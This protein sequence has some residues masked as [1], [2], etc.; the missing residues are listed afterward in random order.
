[1]LMQPC[2]GRSPLLLVLRQN[3]P[4][5]MVRRRTHVCLLCHDEKPGE[6]TQTA[7]QMKPF[8][9]ACCGVPVL[10]SGM[11][12][13]S[14]YVSVRRFTKSTSMPCTCGEPAYM[15]A[16]HRDTPCVS[17]SWASYELL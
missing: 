8:Q 5:C 13:L 16:H 11:R 10:A 9:R 15:S 2:S 14:A 3:V 6:W 4:C 7:T 17:M 1:M 12:L